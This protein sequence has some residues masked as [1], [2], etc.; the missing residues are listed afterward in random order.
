AYA[1]SAEFMDQ[2]IV[3]LLIWMRMPGDTIFAVGALLFGWFVL[4]LWIAPRK[5]PARIGETVQERG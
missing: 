5:A 4:R 1:R 3:H 2:P